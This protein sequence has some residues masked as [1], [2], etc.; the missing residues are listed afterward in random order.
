MKDSDNNKENIIFETN[1]KQSDH[2][3]ADDDQDQVLDTIIKK[4]FT[5]IIDNLDAEINSDIK[6]FRNIALMHREIQDIELE[7]E[8]QVT[9]ASTDA[10][11]DTTES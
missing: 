2:C 8:E 9:L 4:K 7:K 6:S 10:A 11:H 5:D 3:R 1:V